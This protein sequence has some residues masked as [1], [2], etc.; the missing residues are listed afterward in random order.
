MKLLRVSWTASTI[1]RQHQGPVLLLSSVL[2]SRCFAYP[3]WPSSI[4][5]N[6]MRLD[7]EK[8]MVL[9]RLSVCVFALPLWKDCSTLLVLIGWNIGH[10]CR[11]N[12]KNSDDT[13]ALGG[14]V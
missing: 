2:L 14:S 8:C 13:I 11:K 4:H 3:A 6:P 1:I 5:S 7:A 12:F 10:S 9:R